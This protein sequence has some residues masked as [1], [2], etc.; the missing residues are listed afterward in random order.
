MSFEFS[1]L[2][3]LDKSTDKNVDRDGQPVLLSRLAE[4]S[5]GPAGHVFYNDEI[6]YARGLRK[7]V[8]ALSVGIVD[9]AVQIAIEHGHMR[10]AMLM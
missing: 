3:A 4:W 6:A 9:H 1:L 7:A 10:L 5:R 2:L 8:F